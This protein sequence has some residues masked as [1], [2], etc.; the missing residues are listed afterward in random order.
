MQEVLGT[1]PDPWQRDALQALGEGRNIAIR[2]GHG[3]GKTAFLAWVVLWW[4]DCHPQPV[5]PCAAPTKHQVADLLWPEMSRWMS[6]SESIGE[7]LIWQASRVFKVGARR[8]W[9]ATMI[10]AGP[11]NKPE[12]LAGFHAGD[13]LYV[14]DEASGVG[15]RNMA[16]ISGALTTEGAR[17]IL[18]GNPTRATGYFAKRFVDSP[19]S[20]YCRTV[21][22]ESSPRVDPGWV[23][24]MATEWGDE[25][26]EY[27]VRVLGLPPRG[28]A[29]GFIEA[30]AVETA[31]RADL[32]PR[33]P[34]V[35]GVDV[36]RYG[37]DKTAVCVRRGP[38]VL[39]L[40]TFSSR[41]N[42]QVAQL[43]LDAA[44]RF[45]ASGETVTIIVDDGGV[46]GGVTDLLQMARRQKSAPVQIAVQGV[47]F[48]GKGDRWYAT[49][50]GVWWHR[51]RRMMREGALDIPADDDLRTQLTDRTAAVNMSGKTVIESKDHMRDRGVASPD[52]ADALALTVAGGGQGAAFVEMWQR[53]IAE[54]E[55]LRAGSAGK[56]PSQIWIEQEN[57][58][59]ARRAERMHR[60][61]AL[62]GGLSLCEHLW[63]TKGSA[64][65]CVRCGRGR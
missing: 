18:A 56:S 44:G 45:A 57:E 43:V 25:S 8:A 27:R 15:D 42:P 48:G 11:D 64:T 3:V 63:K 33:G 55:V 17:V 59:R 32:E 21:S 9:F 46:G 35:I 34:L 65:Y 20:W 61:A 39:S 22:C 19:S 28:E 38:K 7:R 50:A 16:V 2:S 36:A 4:L 53:Q 30:L 13:L 58:R 47:T 5:V 1:T 54:R 31:M 51:L 62:V 41:S 40:D 24:E 37:R 23:R 12:N 14:V 29:R 6:E 26:D 60:R 49:N 52:K 10:P